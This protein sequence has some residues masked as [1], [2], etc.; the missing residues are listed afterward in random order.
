L[1]HVGIN[2]GRPNAV[3]PT[4]FLR[5]QVARYIVL[6]Q[7]AMNRLGVEVEE[8]V[9]LSYKATPLPLSA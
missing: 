1:Q 5:E 7:D 8:M 6:V 4:E 3:V 9:A 2:R